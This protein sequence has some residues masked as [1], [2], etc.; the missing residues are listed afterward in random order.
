MTCSAC[1]QTQERP[2]CGAYFMGCLA[3]CTRLVLS[4]YPSKPHAAA[5]YWGKLMQTKKCKACGEIFIP[6]R[7]LQRVC[8]ASRALKHARALAEKKSGIR[9]VLLQK[10]IPQVATSAVHAGLLT[11]EM[12]NV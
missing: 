12:F 3:C 7:P 5:L 10:T 4:A 11:E 8:S 1:Q 9:Q 6:A 2:H